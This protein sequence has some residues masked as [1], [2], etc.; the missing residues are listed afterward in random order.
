MPDTNTDIILIDTLKTD[1]KDKLNVANGYD[2]EVMEVK[3]GE[4]MWE[5]MKIK[6]SISLN[7]FQEEIEKALLGNTYIRNLYFYAE[8]FMEHQSGFDGHEELL[9]FKNDFESF[10]T[11][12]TD[13]T[14]RQDTVLAFPSKQYIGGKHDPV[15]QAEVQFYVRYKR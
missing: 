4:H 10:L 1:I 9:K 15:L 2:T 14:Y 6:P 8:L 7:P 13:W 3:I 11:Q 12:S 5:D